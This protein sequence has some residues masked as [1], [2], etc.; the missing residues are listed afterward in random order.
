MLLDLPL[1]LLSVQESGRACYQALNSLSSS[2]NRMSGYSYNYRKWNCTFR[3]YGSYIL[4]LILI[5]L[6]S[7]KIMQQHSLDKKDVQIIRMLT[8]DCRTSYRNM[9][10]DTWCYCKY[11]QIKGAGLVANKIIKFVV[12]MSFALFED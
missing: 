9:G 7:R 2:K 5:M 6:R 12:N 3:T 8:K 4:Y 10:S 1:Q 11:C